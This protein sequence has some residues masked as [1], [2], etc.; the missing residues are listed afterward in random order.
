MSIFGPPGNTDSDAIHINIAGEIVSIPAKVSPVVGDVLVIEDSED[1]NNKKSILLGALP[2]PVTSVAG[3]TGAVALVS[4]D[5]GLGNVTNDAQIALSLGTT[6]GDLI[7]YTASSTAARL[8]VGSD[9]QVLTANSATTEGVEWSTPSDTDADA[10]HVNVAG[11]IAGISSKAT[12]V[13]GDFLVIEDSADSNNK[14][15]IT[16]GNLPYPVTSV[17]GKTG[18]VS[19]VSGDVGLANVTNDAQIPL[20]LGTTKGD[21]I[22]FT[23]SGFAA[24]L[25]VGTNGQVLTA[26]SA[27]TEGVEWASAGGGNDPNAIHVNVAGEIAGI[28]QTIVTASTDLLVI[29]DSSDSNNKKRLELQDL[30]IPMDS[31]QGLRM[32]HVSNNETQIEPGKIR[33]STD[34]FNIIVTSTISESIS[35]SNSTT[36]AVFIQADTSGSNNPIVHHDTNESSPTLQPGYDVFR[37]VGWRRTNG[38]G[39]FLRVEQTGNGIVRQI[40]Y[41]VNRTATQVLSN[42]SATNFSSVSLSDF[43]PNGS[44]NVWLW[45]DLTTDNHNNFLQFRPT[46]TS[47]TNGPW[48]INFLDN[49]TGRVGKVNFKVLAN[50][51]QSI[52]YELTQNTD[53]LDFGVASYEDEL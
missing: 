20:S 16:L 50:S 5:V 42:G 53:E 29:E 47:I 32:S 7:V 49:N 48:Q 22:V 30:P 38:S 19:L 21:V 46:G 35:P 26:N 51:S 33:D 43:V 4:G 11:E 25:S 41:I 31:A 6:K 52:Q 9:G 34:T 27:T 2:Y 36:Y 17:A 37:R 28:S 45:L 23:S 39:N 10:I 44:V 40:H 3:K 12:P 13:N 18:I 1:S 24:R 8:G 15:S 14:K